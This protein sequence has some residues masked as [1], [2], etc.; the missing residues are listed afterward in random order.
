M[1]AQALSIT[2]LE[3]LG[4]HALDR[5]RW[6]RLDLTELMSRVRERCLPPPTAGEVRRV[7]A[8]LLRF[9]SQRGLLGRRDWKRL[10]TKVRHAQL[11]PLD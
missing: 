5:A 2:A 9:L 3:Q 10:R 1:L 4:A 6:L 11:R 7:A 8:H